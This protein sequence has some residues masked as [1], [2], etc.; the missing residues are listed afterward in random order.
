MIVGELKDLVFY[1]WFGIGQGRCDRVGMQGVIVELVERGVV[2][3]V[4][5]AGPNTAA[6]SQRHDGRLH[7]E[8][9]VI[10]DDPDRIANIE[11]VAGNLD[12]LEKQAQVVGFQEF[13]GLFAVGAA[14]VDR[15]RGRRLFRF[16]VLLPRCRRR[17]VIGRRGRGRAVR[18]RRGRVR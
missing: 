4:G 7:V 13:G 18:R 5:V 8:G 3:E 15:P 9:F 12:R 10:F 1:K 2:W 11:L 14:S 6:Q 17:A 16:L